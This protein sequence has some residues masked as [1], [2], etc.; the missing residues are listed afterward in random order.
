MAWDAFKAQ[1]FPG[2]EARK[3]ALALGLDLEKQIIAEKKLVTKKAATVTIQTPKTRRK[4]GMVDPDLRAF[5]AWI[6]A[7]HTAMLLYQED[8]AQ[9]CQQ[10]L[11]EAGLL[12]D[13]TFKALVQALVNAIPR[14]K[15]KGKYV[16][17]E[18]E[19]LEAMRLAF[20]DDLTTP[21]E[22]AAAPAPHQGDL[23]DHTVSV[24]AEGGA[25]YEGQEANQ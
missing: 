14:T 5:P 16:R 1:E 15:Q 7:V 25:A 13:S 18:A 19:T 22:A 6:D 11:R 9:A 3:L 4:R 23:F 21:P 12:N 20:F 24:A 2:D 8:G 10:L 17:P